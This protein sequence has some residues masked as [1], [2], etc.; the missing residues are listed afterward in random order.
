MM[1]TR[2]QI[3]MDH[4]V[5]L[6]G[7]L[8]GERVRFFRDAIDG[9]S[10]AEQLD[11][12]PPPLPVMHLGV[13]TEV[14][15][16]TV[17]GP[18]RVGVL[19]ARDPGG[20]G[21]VVITH[22][23]NSERA[24]DLSGRAKNF[25][26]RALLSQPGAF[27]ATVVVL[28]AAYHDGPLREYTRVAGDLARWMALLAA[29]TAVIDSLVTRHGTESARPTLVTGFSLGGWVANLHRAFHGTAGLY[30]PMLAGA[31]LGRQ[32]FDS[33]YRAMVSR[34]ARADADRL[35]P[36]LDFDARFR[37]ATAPVAP[38]LARHD[39]FARPQD[40]LEDYAHGPVEFLETGHVGAA[41]AGPMLRNHVLRHLGGLQDAAR[42]GT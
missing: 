2:L 13:P 15:V 6:P 26:N 25:L 40:Q 27:D 32:M 11:I 12:P 19:V 5:V 1:G 39:R 36:L 42:P 28:R 30:V 34:A 17:V 14:T 41:L 38:L 37:V 8:G 24:F 23:G 3:A 16:S 18:M 9:P 7:R 22:H 33:S 4:A 29:S 20:Q 21:P 31:H 10:W 35:R